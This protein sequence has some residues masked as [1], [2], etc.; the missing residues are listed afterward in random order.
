MRVST[1][2]AK[3]S[4]GALMQVKDQLGED[5]IILRNRRVGDRIEI[6]ATTDL[7]QPDWTPEPAS[8]RGARRRNDIRDQHLQNELTSLRDTLEQLLAKRSWQDSA[9][10]PAIQATVG[11]R[12]AALGLSKSLGGWI[13]DNVRDDGP[14]EQQWDSSIQ[15]LT[16]CLHLMEM[17]SVKKSK[18]VACVGATGSGKTTCVV[19]LARQAANEFGEQAVGVIALTNGAS[20][21]VG[22]LAE[23]RVPAGIE[24]RSATDKSSLSES[25]AALRGKERI[26]IDT[27]GLSFRDPD[28]T[29]QLEWLAEQI[30]PIRIMLVISAAAQMGTTRELLRRVGATRLDGAII[31]KVDE[32]VSLGG[33][34]DTLIKRRLPLSLLVDNR[35]PDIVPLNTDPVV[36]VDRALA[37][38]NE[39]QVS[40]SIGRSKYAPANAKVFA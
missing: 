35:D 14:L 33:V 36:F 28:M 23:H 27:S 16:S 8:G 20:V 37:L 25:I 7:N 10:V 5:A 3:N 34:I 6:T 24:T 1:F 19:K 4:R 22:Q 17:D 18:L 26:F 29:K 9:N 40:Q 13:S 15:L 39:R 11:Q 38:M 2:V 32:A 31:T 21:E 30:P 12:L